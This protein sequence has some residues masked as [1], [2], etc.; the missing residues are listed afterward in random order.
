MPDLLADS[1]IQ[2]PDTLDSMVDVVESE[3]HVMREEV[4]RSV[5]AELREVFSSSQVGGNSLRSIRD[6]LQQSVG[7]IL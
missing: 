2:D 3:E 6:S 5:G 1:A 7:S 4:S